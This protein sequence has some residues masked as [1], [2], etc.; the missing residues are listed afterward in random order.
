MDWWRQSSRS[1]TLM[2]GTHCHLGLKGV[3]MIKVAGRF[4]DSISDRRQIWRFPCTFSSCLEQR[5]FVYAES[6]LGIISNS[7]SQE[8]LTSWEVGLIWLCFTYWLVGWCEHPNSGLARGHTK[9]D[10]Y[11]LGSVKAAI[12]PHSTNLCSIDHHM[13]S[14][15][16]PSSS[17]SPS[18]SNLLLRFD[19]GFHCGTISVDWWAKRQI[20]VLTLA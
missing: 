14:L 4:I 12:Y 19:A 13:P 9:L 8:S 5:R 10:R 6:R 3:G 2:S 16:V 15:Q 18:R 7:L 20:W 17:T 1:G 11:V